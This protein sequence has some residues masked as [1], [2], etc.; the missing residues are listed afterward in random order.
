MLADTAHVTN[1]RIIIIIIVFCA[2]VKNRMVYSQ[3]RH[4]VLTDQRTQMS[5]LGLMSD[6]SVTP[7]L[8]F[9]VAGE[10]ISA[11]AYTGYFG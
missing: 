8:A 9:W 3:T 6:T 4:L 7:R 5:A 2:E 1:V 11:T 10:V